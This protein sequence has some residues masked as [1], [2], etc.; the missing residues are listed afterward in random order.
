MKKPPDILEYYQP[1]GSEENKVEE[2]PV[3]AS[4]KGLICQNGREKLLERIERVKEEEKRRVLLLREQEEK[5]YEER[6]ARLFERVFEDLAQKICEIPQNVFRKLPI[7][8]RTALF[9]M[10]DAHAKKRDIINSIGIA[11]S[12]LGGIILGI[13]VNPAMMFLCMG[14]IPFLDVCEKGHLR[15]NFLS[16]KRFTQNIIKK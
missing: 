6:Y 9:E 10:I 14:V 11:S 13:S 3:V 15:Y 5:T 8:E 1:F 16:H 7:D 4:D 12:M 2:M